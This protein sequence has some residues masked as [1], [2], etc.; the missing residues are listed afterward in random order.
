MRLMGAPTSVYQEVT[1]VRH[2]LW[3][4]TPDTHGNSRDTFGFR[5]E[6]D[7]RA[8]SEIE[9]GLGQCTTLSITVV[10]RSK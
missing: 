9:Y 7:L 6:E 8:F 3:T 1:V 2:Q 10:I 5:D 4:S